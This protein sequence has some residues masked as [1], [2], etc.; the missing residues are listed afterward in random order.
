M[1]QTRDFSLHSHQVPLARQKK[2]LKTLIILAALAS[3][4]A[5]APS[6]RAQLQ[7][8]LVFSSAG[9]VASRNDQTGVLTAVAGSP[10]PAVNQSL[11][12]DVQGRY[13]FS[14]GTNSIRMFQI[15]NATTGAYQEVACSPFASPNTNQ[16]AF[17]AVEPSG[18]YIAVVNRVGQKSGDG[19]VETFAI[20]PSSSSCTL[21]GPALT[22]VL[23]SATELD[24][25]P[26]GVAQPPNNKEFLVFM[27][28][29]P[30]SSNS[31][32]AQGSEFQALSIDPQTGFVT[33]LQA[34]AALP[35]R[36][37]S[38]AMDPQGRY[39]VTGTQD[40]LQEFGIVQ[41][42]GIG[43][44]GLLGNVQLPQHNFPEALWIDS[45]GAFLY[46]ATSDLLNPI[47]VNIYSVNVQTG[48]LAE[49]SSSPLP[50]FTSVPPYFA[51]PT[52]SFNYGFGSDANTALAFTVDPLTGYFVRSSNSP[53]SIPQIAGN[54]TF[55]IPP[56]QQGISGP[57][58]SLSATSLSF[59]SIQTGN[60]S[61]PQSVTLTSNGGEALSVNSIALGGADPSQFTE[62]DTC[63]VPSALQPT[64]FCSI[65]ITFAPTNTGSQQATLSIMDNAP[66]SPQSVTLTG[67]GAAPPPPAP[68]VTVA[69]DPVTFPPINQGTTSSPIVV[70]V[71]NS[72]NATLHI[73]SVTL[74]GN[75]P[76]EFTMING[77]SGPYAP[78]ATC[79]ITLTF[80]PVAAGQRSATISISDD[81]PNSP[82]LVQVSGTATAVPPTKPV[83]SLS[84]TALAFGTIT[85]GA[86]SPSQSVTV[87]NVGGA[88]LHISSVAL[89]GANSAD[90]TLTN[91]CTA[92]AY[93]VN[94]TCTFSVAF[95]PLVTGPRA[96]SVVLT[97]D[98]SDSAQIVALSG[99]A[100]PTITVGPAPGGSTSA[101]VAPG[102]T[103]V[104]NLQITPGPGYTGTIS[105]AYS[106]APLGA[107]IQAPS[108]LQVSNGNA[109]AFTVMV[110]TS[111]S[112][113]APP[114]YFA[115]RSMPF[116]GLRVLP[117]L[118]A[119]VFLLLLLAGRRKHIL[120]PWTN[121]RAFHV[122]A[123]VVILLFC[124]AG[125]GGGNASA[126]APQ[127]PQVVTP[128]GTSTIT[129][130][131]SATSVN[132][133]PLQ[134]QPIQLTLTV[135]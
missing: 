38:F 16:P 105:L 41:L 95:A 29:N 118:L 15:T 82:Q 108:T 125:C 85:Q 121:R 43:G 72:G 9:A 11:V 119:A 131:P 86:A 40:N 62:S 84:A 96:A 128:Q 97:D 59:G 122:G 101:T 10:F 69:P 93:A 6:A 33:G 90:F 103:A 132:G 109:A 58:V 81:A 74:G 87:S 7:Q 100:N 80:S 27:G 35:E 117:G 120:I 60:S 39:Y 2:Y 31:T 17:I 89:G 51:D 76:G 130:T 34:N 133:K 129:V 53:F 65:S 48:A 106:G 4:A 79:T 98:A 50:G 99:T 24:S 75:N 68:A 102:Q 71:S 112:A 32:I 3:A 104:F 124:S 54:L 52:G 56:G 23:G 83:L 134:L 49:T 25:I 78:N 45:T 126:P 135:N 114:F 46:V 44:D 110:T 91:G 61:T 19:S 26:V 42:L 13:L 12:I 127:T 5:I 28:A 64:K 18:H 111:G 113:A 21:G 1:A 94:S 77:C 107:N 30:Q 123:S 63:Q 55:S 14:I 92:S 88:P 116:S 36:G 70:T 73:S 115:P 22:P 57:S 66:G 67:A 47:V 8:P 20:A 37:D